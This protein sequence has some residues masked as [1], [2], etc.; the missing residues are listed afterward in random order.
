MLNSLRPDFVDQ[1][2]A[3]DFFRAYNQGGY[4]TAGGLQGISANVPFTTNH[5]NDCM[6]FAN[7][8][9]RNSPSSLC[10]TFGR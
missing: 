1:T 2:K 7:L 8:G 6:E 10:N 4:L 5:N 3:P 9:G